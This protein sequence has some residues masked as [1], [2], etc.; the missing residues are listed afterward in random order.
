[1]IRDGV[2]NVLVQ[3]NVIVG[4][5]GANL[6]NAISAYTDSITILGNLLNFTKRWSANPATVNGVYT[7]TVPDIADAVAISQSSS[8]IASIVTAQGAKA[9]GQIT[10]VKV[11]NGGSGYTSATV[12]F[13]GAGTG[14]AA[15]VWV[16]GGTVI[17]IQMTSFGSGYGASTTATISGNGTGATATAQVGLQVWKN[18][19]L[20][21]DCLAAVTFAAAGSSPAQ[22][23][24]TGAPITVPAGA[25]IDWIG[26]GSGWRAA[27]FT[28]SDYVSPNGD[29]SVT[30]KTQSGDISLHPAGSGA[31]RILSDAEFDGL[32]GA[33]R[34]RFAAERG[35]ST[36]RLDLQEFEWGRGKHLL[37][38]AGGH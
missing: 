25:T 12:S 6:T 18:K 24:W 11:A 35:C 20:A 29:G 32:G 28:Q 30:L 3:D 27:R 8:P 38:E 7:L 31:V 37:G 5:P 15:K 36:C 23:N 22:S 10:F 19:E 2:Q 1:M 33:D 21:I 14:A 26:T 34:A 9:A 16:S 17:G 13:S 4:Q